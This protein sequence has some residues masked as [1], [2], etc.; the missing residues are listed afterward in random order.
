[1]KNTTLATPSSSKR[2]L[3]LVEDHPVTREGFAR[4]LNFEPDLEVCGQ[5]GTAAEALAAVK[6]THPDLVIVDISL[7]GPS[8]LELL[9]DIALLHPKLLTMVLS[10]H[11]ETLYAE[12]AFR[13]GAHGYIMKSA[14]TEQILA[15]IRRVLAGKTYLSEP[16]NERL[17]SRLGSRFAP[18]QTSVV[19][20]LSD[21]ELEVFMLIGQGQSTAEIASILNLSPNTVATH[22]AHIQGKLELAS[23]QELVVRAAQ[24]VQ[25]HM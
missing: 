21:R 8:G 20:R 6:A 10:T 16:M 17:L 9:K 22:R 2:R 24:W 15:A 23:L 19:E 5:V 13:A 1:M 12:R 7:G 25:A 14:S 18:D 4:L 11:D 3:L